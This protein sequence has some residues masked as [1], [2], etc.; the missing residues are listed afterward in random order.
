MELSN[1][2][3]NRVTQLVLTA[4]DQTY[5]PV[6]EGVPLAPV[7][8]FGGTRMQPY[9]TPSGFVVVD[10]MT[11]PS[12]GFRMAFYKNPETN[13]VLAIPAGT[14]GIDLQDYSTDLLYT[15]YNQWDNNA[16]VF[17]EKLGRIVD[18]DT[19][20]YFG[21]QSLGGALAQFAA[22]AFTETRK[23]EYIT[24]TNP[25]T[26]QQ[27]TV[28][29]PLYN[30]SL[31]NVAVIT[32]AA[33][34]VGDVL[35]SEMPQFDP[36]GSD[37]QQ[38]TT[39][40]YTT[41]GE[42]INMVGGDMVG[43]NGSIYYLPTDGQGDIGYLHRI[44]LGFWDSLEKINS[45]LA[46]LT[47]SPRKTLD[48]ADLQSIGAAV[49]LIGANG[50]MTGTESAARMG[51]A[52]LVGGAL[53]PPGDT[54]NMIAEVASRYLGEEA[55]R[56]FGV[57]A[58][59]AAKL[60]L[61]TNPVAWL[62][63]VV[64]GLGIANL[65]HL[66]S[67]PVP[68]NQLADL[69]FDPAHTGFERTSFQTYDP[70]GNVFTVVK[71]I[72]AG[73]PTVARY[74]VRSAD[75]GIWKSSVDGQGETCTSPSG[76]TVRWQNDSPE[77]ILGYG[78][79][80]L[81]TF[82]PDTVVKPG[83]MG[84]IVL[85]R[86][87][88]TQQDLEVR[89]TPPPAG[90]DE[91]GVYING[92]QAQVSSM[93]LDVPAWEDGGHF[94]YT[95]WL[96]D[97]PILDLVTGGDRY[98]LDRLKAGTFVDGSQLVTRTKTDGDGNIIE[99]ETKSVQ[100]NGENSWSV[101]TERKGWEWDDNGDGHFKGR[102]TETNSHILEADNQ[103]TQHNTTKVYNARN[104]HTATIDTKLRNGS[105]SQIVSADFG[106]N[107][108]VLEY[109]G[110]AGAAPKLT[111]VVELNDTSVSDQEALLSRLRELGLDA[112]DFVRMG[113]NP[114]VQDTLDQSADAVD[115]YVE[116]HPS[117]YEAFT[118]T[119]DRYGP[120]VID[121]LSLIKA[122]QSGEPLPIAASG[123]RLANDLT[124]L[125][126]TPNLNLSGAANVGSGILSL[127]SLD[128]ALKRGDTLGA[129][130]AGA[131]AITYGATAYANFAGYNSLS[132]AV[133]ANAFGTASGAIG[134]VGQALP[135]LAIINS[136][137]NGD[138]VGAAVGVISMI[139][140][141]QWVGVVYA[142]YSIFDSED[143]PDPW[144]S[145][146]FVW[147]GTG[148]K[149]QV[150]G[151]TGGDAAVSG[152]ME[153]TLAT[154]NALIEQQRQANPGSQLG[155]IPNR[156]PTVGYDM[157]GYR[158][159]DIDPLTGEEQHPELRFDTDGNPYNAEPGSTESFRS[160]AEGMIYSALER[161]AIAPQWEVQT[162]KM[163]GTAGDPRAGLTEE[164]RA[165]RDGKLA[166]P[167]EGDT[168]TFRPVALDLDG[169][170]IETVARDDSTVHFDVDNS[171]YLKHT[172]WLGADDA[173]LTLDRDYNGQTDSGREMF[174]NAAV[175]LSR[176]G[177]GGMAWNR[178][179]VVEVNDG[180]QRMAA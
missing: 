64:A 3:L 165:G 94:K 56:A 55:G 54:A 88:I 128:A 133:N 72:N 58:E 112:D 159:T 178:K 25:E 17:F 18:T 6:W 143:V 101:V 105:I 132:T 126:G 74:Q 89:Y 92:E 109:V 171:D 16:E 8:N 30:H 15:G 135:Y 129:V 125:N 59:V 28:S 34:G 75:G 43:G 156:M 1:E 170:G 11:D 106:D 80:T 9:T 136:L 118:D 110:E 70:D 151:K 142:I 66:T 149:L 146:Q 160:I 44:T 104:E 157:S 173:F 138:E 103:I 40:H 99:V 180:M 168:Q 121:A 124:E 87:S 131:S 10:T 65:A 19:K 175:A 32:F 42:V 67:D 115:Q 20:I 120:A 62:Q 37:V 172:G 119:V 111:K 69:G 96:D 48:T 21:A 46:G 116:E 122:I 91:C 148:I 102:I 85:R 33:P 152:V 22:A 84:S 147:D 167:V 47:L 82:P 26:G 78:G 155:I 97:T 50:Q 100:S 169:D 137:A 150:V 4:S 63:T 13:E 73:D 113:D 139:P 166:A 83:D 38:M 77:A 145:G 27:T 98:I 176:R 5:Y 127:M 57:G 179:P 71:D 114:L 24:V 7:N 161:G 53:S 2:E 29:N 153:G 134:A 177:L 123:L 31:D 86:T 140:G 12:T 49:A 61:I 90:S 117:A 35:A 107:H 51:L 52:L 144:G 164:E 162:A 158:Y 174:S 163:Q 154:L 39:L 93:T 141:M 76:F 45:D 41:E 68:D 130:T 108:I 36:N 81:G 60:L 79:K 14:D 23:S 95:S